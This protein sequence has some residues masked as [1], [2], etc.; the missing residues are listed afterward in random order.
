MT[1]SAVS[2]AAPPQEAA[3]PRRHRGFIGEAAPR[4]RRSW[5]GGC[6]ACA[7]ALAA[8]RRAAHERWAAAGGLVYPKGA[9][10]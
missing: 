5:L 3:P 1:R 10:L 6:P 9:E 2:P 4:W 8:T 7:E